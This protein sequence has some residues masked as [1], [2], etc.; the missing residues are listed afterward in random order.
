MGQREDAP[1]F[2]LF[3]SLRGRRVVVI[4]GG[5]IA[6][7]RVRAL[8]DFGPKIMV[9]A[10]ECC[11]GLRELAA[12]GKIT[13]LD[14]PY[15]LGDVE[16]SFFCLAATDRREVNR[17]VFTACRAAGVPVNVADRRE[18]C[19][20][21]FPALARSGPLVAGITA[22][23]QDHALAKEAAGAVRSLFAAYGDGT[24]ETWERDDSEHGK[25]VDTHWQQ[26]QQ[27]GAGTEPAG[28]EADS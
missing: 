16:G 12:A 3:V 26:G 21:Y 27:A 7:R 19:D 5:R 17:A 9:V 2:P 4:G 20:F 10:P 13:W 6:L 11:A 15:T 18:E 23:G 1:F 14:R 8:A 28:D 22:S 24:R 25:T